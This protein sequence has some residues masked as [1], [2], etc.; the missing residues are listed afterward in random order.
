MI[1]SL[2]FTNIAKSYASLI[3][4][5]YLLEENLTGNESSVILGEHF[6]RMN[7]KEIE[8]SRE[9]IIIIKFYQ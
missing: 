9:S 8:T 3:F 1:A 7:S 6:E 2:L 4:N 5:V